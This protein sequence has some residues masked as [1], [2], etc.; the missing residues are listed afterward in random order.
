MSVE[1]RLCATEV[2]GVKP[3]STYDFA[4]PV[5]QVKAID[6]V[7][8]QWCRHLA[9]HQEQAIPWPTTNAKGVKGV[10]N[11]NKCLKLWSK[12]KEGKLPQQDDRCSGEALAG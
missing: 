5:E 8:R 3:V 2:I 7:M 11:E 1:K 12:R 10:G 6:L 9:A 4:S